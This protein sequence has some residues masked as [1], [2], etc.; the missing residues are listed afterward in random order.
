MMFEGLI[1][2][3]CV[4]GMSI[5]VIKCGGGQDDRHIFCVVGRMEEALFS[6]NLAE[7]EKE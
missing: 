5:V 1:N 2:G 7:V 6:L 4:G 3:Q